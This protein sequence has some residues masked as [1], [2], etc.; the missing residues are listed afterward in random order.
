V[1]ALTAEGRRLLGELRPDVAAIEDEMLAPL[2]E[3][4]A[5]AL[6]R[7]MLSCRDALLAPGHAAGP[8]LGENI[9]AQK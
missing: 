1:I 3:T 7:A 5:K 6:R 9:S 4:Q 8:P 2:S